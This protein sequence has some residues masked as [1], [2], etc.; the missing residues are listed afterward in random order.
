MIVPDASVVVAALVLRSDDRDWAMRTLARTRLV[1]PHLLTVEVTNALRRLR[2][3]GRIEEDDA[4][5]AIDGLARLPIEFVPYRPFAGRVWDFAGTLTSYD[6]W[7]VAAAER[8]G[9]PLATLDLRLA[10]APGPVCAF[11]TPPSAD[12]A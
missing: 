3:A 10:R 7:Y 9:A 2:T 5:V 4:V 11:L 6:A 8:L 1:A 12:H